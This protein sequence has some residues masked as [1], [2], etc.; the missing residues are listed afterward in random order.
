M[1]VFKYLRTVKEIAISIGPPF[2]PETT[3]KCLLVNAP[4]V[5]ASAWAALRVFLPRETAAKVSIVSAKD[6]AAHLLEEIDA[7]QLP[8]F[9]GGKRD[10]SRGPYATPRAEVVPAGWSATTLE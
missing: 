5:A 7:E 1:S 3:Y 9:L 10:T 6:T 4:R 8:V 2:Y